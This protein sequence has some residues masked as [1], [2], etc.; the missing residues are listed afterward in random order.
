MPETLLTCVCFLCNC[1]S[2]CHCL[3]PSV[4]LDAP[5]CVPPW[6]G[7]PCVCLCAF[8]LQRPTVSLEQTHCPLALRQIQSLP[9][10]TEPGA[11]EAP[12]LSPSFSPFFSTPL[13][14]SECTGTSQMGPPEQ[15]KEDTQLGGGAGAEE[16]CSKL[17]TS[18]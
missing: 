14:G 12:G 11:A 16:G 2:V 1:E 9:T 18:R 13:R 5:P 7:R 3:C 6:C 4:P 10:S 8:R 15:G 17:V